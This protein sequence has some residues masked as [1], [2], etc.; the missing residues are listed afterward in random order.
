MTTPCD[1]DKRREIVFHP[2]PPGQVEEAM[3]FLK[4]LPNL[5]VERRAPL[6]IE[7][8]YCVQE[9]TLEAIEA[10][11]I[12]IGCHL[13]ATLL[14]RLKRALHYYVERIQRDN[15]ALPEIHTKDYSMAHAEAWKKRPHGD[16]DDTPAEW[17]QYK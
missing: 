9:Y 8:R 16:H 13:E 6:L 11:L 2:T 15:M 10:A 17:R 7:V 4:A 12:R 3:A 5:E 1:V 14:I